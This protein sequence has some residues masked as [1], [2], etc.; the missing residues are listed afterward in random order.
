MKAIRSIWILLVC[1]LLPTRDHAQHLWIDSV[2]KAAAIQKED[3]NKIWTLRNL[4]DYYVFNDPDSGIIYAKQALTLAQKLKYDRGIFWSIVSLDHS[5]FI[6]GNYALEL[7][8]ALKALPIARGLNDKYAFGWSNGM[9]A[10]SYLN[11]GDYVTAMQY[12][13]VVLATMVDYFPNELFS[14]YAVSV[15]IY[16]GLHNYDSALIYGRKS[17]ELLKAQP[18]LYNDNGDGGKYAKN[19]VYLFLG[20][21]Y[22][23]NE[24]Y[25]SALYYYRK[26]LPFGDELNLKINVIQVFNG[27]AKIFWVRHQPDTAIWYAK[28]VL[29][30][31]V[32]NAYPAARIQ[33]ATLL[34]DVYEGENNT[35]SSLKYLRISVN[36]KDS[37]Y[38]REKTIAFQNL[39]LKDLEKKK[40]VLTATA[41]LKHRYAIYLLSGLFIVLIVIATIVIRNRRIKQL[42]NIRNSI[43]DD[44][45]DDIGS[46]LSSIS[47]MNELAKAK[48]PQAIPL[49]TSIGEYT[50]AIQDN[51]SDI[52]WTVNPANDHFKS[53]S[54]RMNLFA[55]EILDAKNI[56]FEFISDP[57]LN[58]SK[59]TM[60]Q[61]KSLY[62]F[63]KETINN[64]AKHSGATR[65][66][67][68]IQKKDQGIE[69]NIHDN[70]NGFDTTAIYNGNGMSSLKRRA[71]DLSAAYSIDSQANKGT[72]I[73]LKFKIT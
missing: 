37:I 26:S 8:Y 16:V 73:Q 67:V 23:A 53:L 10:D 58:S 7:D 46:T 22:Q 2:R 70:G 4:S 51:M 56:Q 11:L 44:L 17:L 13:R 14:G 66:V 38:N 60:K 40:E 52:V 15:P 45:H 24:M 9:L 35:D 20:E 42:Q 21:A 54:D 49:L 43:A 25:D 36:L 27:M 33:A 6:T 71:E 57:S 29:K 19:Q 61:R 69:I 50:E 18:A 59:L 62:L 65:I 64:S 34:A 12:A 55:T 3:T 32:T 68:N 5:L 39:L 47:I 28:K 48:S 41:A 1:G 63:F 72:R 30:D 31:K